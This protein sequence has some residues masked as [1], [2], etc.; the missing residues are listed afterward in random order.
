MLSKITYLLLRFYIFIELFLKYNNIITI[1]IVTI[2]DFI[3]TR[4]Y[5]ERVFWHLDVTWQNI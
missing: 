1:N 2:T 5:F 4:S 3:Y